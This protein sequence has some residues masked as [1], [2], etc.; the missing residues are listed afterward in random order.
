MSKDSLTIDYLLDTTH[1]HTQ[2]W[3]ICPKQ[4]IQIFILC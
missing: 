1:T 4:S 3:K 2:S